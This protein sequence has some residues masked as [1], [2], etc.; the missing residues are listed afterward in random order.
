MKLLDIIRQLNDFDDTSVI[1]ARPKWSP[2]TQAVVAREPDDGTTP[3]AAAGMTF[4]L[5]IRQAKQVVRQRRR[6][7]PDLYTP[8]TLC[9]AIVYF[10]IYDELEPLPSFRDAS[11]ELPVAV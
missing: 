6:G 3:P 10:A 7:R 5:S 11:Y 9:E 2:S 1:Y 8:E 4:M